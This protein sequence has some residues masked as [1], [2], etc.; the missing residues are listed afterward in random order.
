MLKAALHGERGGGED[1]GGDGF[2]DELA[3][4]LGDVDGRGLDLGSGRAGATALR[5]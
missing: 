1:D 4:E 5:G 2:E 3:E